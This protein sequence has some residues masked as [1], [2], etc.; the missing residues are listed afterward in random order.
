VGALLRDIRAWWLAG[1]CVADG[2]TCRAELARRI[3]G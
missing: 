1:G 2:A 3:G